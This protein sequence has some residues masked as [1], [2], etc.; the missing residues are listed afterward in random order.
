MIEKSVIRNTEIGAYIL[1]D[2]DYLTAH[3]GKPLTIMRIPVGMYTADISVKGKGG[4]FYPNSQLKKKGPLRI[5]SGRLFVGDPCSTFKGRGADK[6]WD[7]FI[8]TTNLMK[9][10]PTSVKV[11]ETGG[12]GLGEISFTLTKKGEIS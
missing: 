10:V 7:T 6:R 9:K 11:I 3:G 1:C 12:D 8:T 2:A 4:P 5:S